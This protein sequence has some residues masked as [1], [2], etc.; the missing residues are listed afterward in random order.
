MV[1]GEALSLAAAACIGGAPKSVRSA[2]SK[3]GKGPGVLS[4]SVMA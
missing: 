2:S 4:V 1:D 3:E